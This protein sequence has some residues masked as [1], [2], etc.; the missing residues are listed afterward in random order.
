MP[1]AHGCRSAGSTQCLGVFSAPS[2]LLVESC[3][4]PFCLARGSE[5]TRPVRLSA[6]LR[7]FAMALMRLRRCRPVATP[8]WRKSRCGPIAE[9]PCAP[10]R[11]RGIGQLSRR[12]SAE[13]PCASDAL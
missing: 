13:T 1:R 10:Q 4:D 8:E 11:L 7:R 2:G 9:R 5:D 3:G 6:A 12:D